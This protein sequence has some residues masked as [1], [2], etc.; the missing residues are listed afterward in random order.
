[1]SEAPVCQVILLAGPS[2]SGKTHLALT[3]GL[4]VLALD[5]FYKGGDDPS[6][7]RQPEL[8][9]TDWDDPASWDAAAAVRAVA[10]ICRTG[11]AEVPVYDIAHDRVVDHRSFDVG[12]FPV[13]V[14]EGL[15]AAEIVADCRALGILA[16]AI[17]LRRSPWKNYLRRL[18]RD[19]REHRKPPLTVIRRA[20]HLMAVEADVVR[21]QQSLGCR[22]AD[23]GGLRRGLRQWA[24]RTRM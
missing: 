9:I 16:D 19:L 10:E 22:P 5:D 4:P 24:A 13:F 15:F 7:P 21:R 3:S 12:A 6:L 1:V 17:V 14:A 20:R 8:G 11:R 23:A 2:G 18:I